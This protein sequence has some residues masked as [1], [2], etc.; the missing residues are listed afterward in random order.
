MNVNKKHW[1]VLFESNTNFFLYYFFYTFLLSKEKK[2][3]M[4]FYYC[5][6]NLTNVNQEV[7]IIT[8]QFDLRH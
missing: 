2:K 5:C 4:I 1:K 7:N 8:K 6:K 3:N